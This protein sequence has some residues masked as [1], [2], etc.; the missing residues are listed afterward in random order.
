M[1]RE[2]RR[3]AWEGFLTDHALPLSAEELSLLSGR[4]VLITGAGG[5][6]GS[7]IARTLAKA[8]VAHLTL[9]DIAEYGLYRLEG[10]LQRERRSTL[11]TFAIGSVNDGALLAELFSGSPPDIVFHAAARKHV[12][13]MEENIFAAAETNVLGTLALVQAAERA[14]IERLILLST[15]KAVDP[16]SVMGATKR[17]AEQIVLSARERQHNRLNFTCLRLCNV[18]GSTGSV[19]PLF[20]RQLRSGSP[21]T[22]T[23]PQ[24]TRLFLSSRDAVRHIIRAVTRTTHTGM[25]IPQ[26]SPAVR[27]EELAMFLLDRAGRREDGKAIIYTGLRAADKLHE[28]LLSE[29]EHAEQGPHKLHE[30]KTNFNAALL[31]ALIPVLARAVAVRDRHALLRTMR[32]L[33]PEYR[34]PASLARDVLPEHV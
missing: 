3:P 9:L 8:D 14:G 21:L 28:Q 11:C 26:V 10:Q 12:P 20:A 7:A 27:I 23:D 2:Q 13:L 6:L 29:A 15:D 17:I 4:H 33:V 30:V 5:F 31:G 16:I 25:L 1:K 19:A 24:A 32:Q 22:V 18:L 34:A